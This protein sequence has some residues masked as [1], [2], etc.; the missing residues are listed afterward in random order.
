MS[1]FLLTMLVS[2]PEL[3]E[4][5]TPL[6]F[7]DL[8]TAITFLRFLKDFIVSLHQY[9]KDKKY[10]VGNQLQNADESEADANNENGDNNNNDNNYIENNAD[11]DNANHHNDQYFNHRNDEHSSD[12]DSDYDMDSD[13]KS[14]DFVDQEPLGRFFDETAMQYQRRE[15]I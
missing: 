12:D 15:E 4:I 7:A 14:D 9:I 6:Y 8:V 2:E 5:Y 1:C 3:L 10:L 11:N 13:S